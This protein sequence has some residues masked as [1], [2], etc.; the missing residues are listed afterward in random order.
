LNAVARVGLALAE[1][2][3]AHPFEVRLPETTFRFH[4]AVCQR[5]TVAVRTLFVPH[6]TALRLSR[7]SK[8]R[9]VLLVAQTLK[10]AQ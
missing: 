5:R 2:T 10:E 9:V 3:E 6:P 8:K 1:A 4:M 7:E